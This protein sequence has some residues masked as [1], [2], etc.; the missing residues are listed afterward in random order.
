MFTLRRRWVSPPV[1]R[2]IKRSSMFSV[3]TFAPG[4]LGYVLIT[5]RHKRETSP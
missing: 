3:T 1:K 2:T 4:F 5:L